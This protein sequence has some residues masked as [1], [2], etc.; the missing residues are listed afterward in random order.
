MTQPQWKALLPV[1]TAW[2]NGELI[3]FR[4]KPADPWELFP[5]NGDP[6]WAQGEWKVWPMPKE[7][8]VRIGGGGVIRLYETQAL[9]GSDVMVHGGVIRRVVPWPGG[10]PTS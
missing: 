1:I 6:A 10:F 8:W 3:A 5:T 9:A 7:W 2:A 4:P